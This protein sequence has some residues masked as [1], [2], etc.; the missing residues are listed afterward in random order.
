MVKNNSNENNKDDNT[1]NQDSQTSYSQRVKRTRRC[2][3]VV[4]W[5]GRRP[6]A[7]AALLRRG[8]CA[9]E[10]DQG[11]LVT[12][13]PISHKAPAGRDP[14][15]EM[16]E[17]GATCDEDG[18]LLSFSPWEMIELEATRESEANFLLVK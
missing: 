17:L 10:R 1:N 13:N 11:D 8:S 14:T 4:C 5:R 7:C 9:C 12:A 2:S 6:G 16:I 3:A 18:E 15:C